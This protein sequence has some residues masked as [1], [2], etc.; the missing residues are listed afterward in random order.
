[1]R[2]HQ[3][4]VISR[5]SLDLVFQVGGHSGNL[6][7]KLLP[8]NALPFFSASIDG[9][10]CQFLRLPGHAPLKQIHDA[11]EIV[12]WGGSA[13]IHD[14]IAIIHARVLFFLHGQQLLSLRHGDGRPD[15]A[16]RV[17]A[18]RQIH[19]RLG[20]TKLDMNAR[21]AASIELPATQHIT[22]LPSPILGDA[23]QRIRSRD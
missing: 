9:A 5:A 23:R 7:V 6:Q 17:N 4:D 18:N 14:N 15:A 1:M 12:Q 2:V 13:I 10:V 3:H 8:S 21:Q 20:H 16:N 22:N 19:H 11:F